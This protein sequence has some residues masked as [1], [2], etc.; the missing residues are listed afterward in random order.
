MSERCEA[1]GLLVG[2]ERRIAAALQIHRPCH[3]DDTEPWRCEHGHYDDALETG[4]PDVP[5]VCIECIGGDDNHF[6]YPCPTARALGVQP[7]TPQEDTQP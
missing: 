7:I 3:T 6:P 2:A 5:P 4:I 1:W